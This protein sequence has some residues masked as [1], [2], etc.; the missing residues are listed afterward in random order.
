M[1]DATQ[2]DCADRTPREVLAAIG[3]SIGK[4][5]TAYPTEACIP[6]G[7]VIHVGFFFDGFGRHRDFDD[8]ATSRYSNICRL[9]EAHREN[10]DPRR[11]DFPNQFWYPFYYSGLGTD[12]NKEAREGLVTSAVMKAGKEAATAAEK[13][14]VDIGKKVAGVD[15]LAVKPQSALSDGVKKGHHVVWR[16]DAACRGYRSP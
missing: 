1:A 13:K 15:R 7:A 16:N 12:L 14:A 5:R 9:W 6:C 3:D 4:S 11:K 2:L 8:P 10:K